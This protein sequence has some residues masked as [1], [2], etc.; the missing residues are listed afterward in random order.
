MEKH[1]AYLGDGVYAAVDAYRGL[2]L[3]TEDGIEA[4]NTIVLEPE[5]LEALERYIYARRR[6]VSEGRTR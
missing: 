3:T 5:V 6:D 1:K 4:T 2:V